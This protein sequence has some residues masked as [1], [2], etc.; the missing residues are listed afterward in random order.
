[1]AGP[2]FVQKH[3]CGFVIGRKL[4]LV[5]KFEGF[6]FNYPL[7]TQRDWDVKQLKLGLI[8]GIG[9]ADSIRDYGGI[10][11]VHGLFLLEGARSLG[12]RYAEMIDWLP[13]EEFWESAH[14]LRAQMQIQVEKREADFREPD[15]FKS[16]VPV[17][18]SLLYDVMLHQDNPE[19]V[20]KNVL[21]ATSRCVC[22]AQPVLK[23]EMFVLP[24]GTVNLQ[25]YPSELHDL[26]RNP[27][28]PVAS[29][30]TRFDTSQW[31]WGQTVSYFQSVF[32]GYGWEIEH[33][34]GCHLSP[35]WNYAFMRFVLR[36]D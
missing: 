23:E 9:K 34:E 1:L 30:G 25:F 31:M 32:Y 17:D 22:L 13:S 24:N 28:W 29:T 20:M 26:L 27:M 19:E 7:S 2:E 36:R 6:R 5:D 35:H 21:A 10:W 4:H 11:G 14:A 15:L 3:W 16:L 12:C 33:L 18:V 8:A